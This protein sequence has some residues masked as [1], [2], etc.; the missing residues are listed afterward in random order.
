MTLGEIFV[1][2]PRSVLKKTN[3]KANHH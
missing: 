3:N 2:K 1:C